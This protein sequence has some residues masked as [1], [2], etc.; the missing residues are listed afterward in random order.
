ML[1]F[2]IWELSI[3]GVITSLPKNIKIS[4]INKQLL[5][6][7]GLILILTSYFFATKSLSQIAVLPVLGASF[8]IYFSSGNDILGKILSSKLFVHIGKLSYSLYLWHWPVIVLFKN[9]EYRFITV[10]K[11]C[12]YV[13]LVMITYILS[14]LSYKLVE[15]KLR[16]YN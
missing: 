16:H 11:L 2:R 4:K 1:P 5:P 6:L 12:I 13:L 9:L 15:T 8:I 14:F 7:L 10:N 3:G